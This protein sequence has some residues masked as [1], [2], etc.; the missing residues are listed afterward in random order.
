LANRLYQQ[1]PDPRPTNWFPE[2]D[3]LPP[4]LLLR[5]GEFD[6]ALASV[7]IM[8]LPPNRLAALQYVMDGI[9][10]GSRPTRDDVLATCY[11]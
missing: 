10:K 6:Q 9:V 1:Y 8:S 4:G 2:G 3:T 11:R 5:R 7:E